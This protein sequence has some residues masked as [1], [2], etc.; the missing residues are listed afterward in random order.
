MQSV[1]Q[2]RLCLNQELSQENSSAAK[3]ER[4]EY[5]KSY[6]KGFEIYG[7]SSSGTHSFLRRLTMVADIFKDFE[8]PCKKFLAT[9]L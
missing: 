9:P 5:T 1:M 4:L 8:P 6:W 7:F 2:S 3:K